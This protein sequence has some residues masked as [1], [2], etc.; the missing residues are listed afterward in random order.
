MPSPG[1][2]SGGKIT[3]VVRVIFV[4]EATSYDM[5][6]PSN[7]TFFNEIN[8]RLVA[9]IVSSTNGFYQVKLPP[10]KYSLFVIENDMYYANGSD[11]EHIQPA[12]VVENEATKMQI[13]ITYNAVY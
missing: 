13:D 12:V 1:G 4:Y 8:T 2:P 10:G 3:P 7:G 5:V 9:V 6:E 11:G